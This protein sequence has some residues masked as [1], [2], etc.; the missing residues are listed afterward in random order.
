MRLG[1]W[2][3]QLA[4]AEL[5]RLGY[6]ILATNYR[7]RRGEIDIVARQGDTLVFVEVKTRK[8]HGFSPA[9]EGVHRR[10][11]AR[12]RLLAAMWLSANPAALRDGGCRFDVVAI[13]VDPDQPA[14]VEVIAHAF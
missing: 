12:I 5:V 1:P 14:K 11:Q 3:E 7:T 13:H 10:K 4:V 8:S 2:G 6:T 9:V